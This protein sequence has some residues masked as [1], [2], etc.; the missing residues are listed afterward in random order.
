VE[1]R[2]HRRSVVHVRRDDRRPD[3]GSL[4][5]PDQVGEPFESVELTTDDPQ[6]GES[7]L[8]ELAGGAK[9]FGI[10]RQTKAAQLH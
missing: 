8:L 5:C 4:G 2:S 9:P 10:D 6:C 7:E 1:Q 3:D